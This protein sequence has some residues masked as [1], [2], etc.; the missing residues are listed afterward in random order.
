MATYTT[1][2]R[3]NYFKV[4]DV[5]AFLDDISKAGFELWPGTGPHRG[6]VAIHDDDGTRGLSGVS[7]QDTDDDQD[8]EFEW[9]VVSLIAPHLE[10]GWVCEVASIG[11]ERKRFLT[12]DSVAFNHTGEDTAVWRTIDFS[13]SEIQRLGVNH[14]EN[15][16]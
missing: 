6:L 12:G 13:L 15:A 8:V 7:H 10:E 9:D 2:T 1:M 11:G 16:Y 3:S 14:T 5:D 4:H